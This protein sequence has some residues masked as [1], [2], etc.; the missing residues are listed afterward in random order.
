MSEYVL[1]EFV[2]KECKHT[3][4]V[5]PKLPADYKPQICTEC[6]NKIEGPRQQQFMTKLFAD[7]QDIS[8]K[9]KQIEKGE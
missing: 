3:V 6:Y 4:V 1:R 8:T 7:I 5:N 2:C 9:I